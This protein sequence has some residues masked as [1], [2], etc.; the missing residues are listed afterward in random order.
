[1]NK[2]KP[3]LIGLLGM[4]LAIL[5]LA[6]SGCTQIEPERSY[7]GAED[8][9]YEIV[10]G[11]DVPYKVNEKIFKSKEKGFGFSY[12]DGNVMYVAFGFGTQS[13][14]GFSIQVLAVKE[15]DTAVLIEAQL[16][17]PGAEEVIT[18]QPSQPYLILKMDN[19]EK[20]VE[21]LLH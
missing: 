20:D 18:P 4:W 2:K 9:A 10:S 6:C 16:I 12:R 17:P 21:F 19:V 11:S 7:E 1:M 13:T 14:G 5:A 8:R 3:W 15:T